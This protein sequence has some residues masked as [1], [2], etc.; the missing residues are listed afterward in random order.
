LTDR[1][2]RKPVRHAILRALPDLGV[3]SYGEVPGDV[4]IEPV[5]M[6]RFEDVF[7]PGEVV[8]PAT[9]NATTD[10]RTVHAA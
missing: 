3:I 8:R 10:P 9:P 7:E 1:S 4:L 6:V 2:L 5:E